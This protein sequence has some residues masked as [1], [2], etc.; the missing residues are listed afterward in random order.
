MRFPLYFKRSKGAGSN[1][2][3]GSD[4]APTF[5]TSKVDGAP[6]GDNIMSHKLSRP[7]NR[8]AIGYQYEGVGS[9]VTLP[10]TIYVWDDASEQ[11]YQAATGT[12]TNGDITYLRCAVLADPVQTYQAT[13]LGVPSHGCDVLVVVAENTEPDGTYHFVVG[14]DSAFF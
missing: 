8:V 1:P 9:P 7:F 10:V 11:W 13:Q 4:T 12:L 6:N 2:A 5:G 14:P 3:M